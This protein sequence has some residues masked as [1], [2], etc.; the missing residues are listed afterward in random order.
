MTLLPVLAFLNVGAEKEPMRAPEWAIAARLGAC[1]IT[2]SETAAELSDLADR[3]ADAGYTVVTVHPGHLCYDILDYDTPRHW[4]ALKRFVDACHA[5]GMRVVL[6]TMTLWHDKQRSPQ[7]ERYAGWSARHGATTYHLPPR[8]GANAWYSC[9]NHPVI[10]DAHVTKLPAL[11]E[12]TGADGFMTDALIRPD[13]YSCVCEHCRRTFRRDTG[14]EAP[15]SE[16]AD[17]WGRHENPAYRA[18]LLWRYQ[19]VTDFLLEIREALA[20]MERPRALLEY[21]APGIPSMLKSATDHEVLADAGAC[22]IGQEVGVA[23]ASQYNWRF[24][25]AKLNHVQSLCQLRGRVPYAIIHN[26]Y[27]ESCPHLFRSLTWL[28]GLRKWEYPVAYGAVRGVTVSRSALRWDE[29]HEDLLSP[30]RRDADVA[31][32]YSRRSYVLVKATHREGP[33]SKDPLDAEYFGWAEALLE[34]D[35]P[36]HS[37]LD[38]DLT[39]ERLGDY[40]VLILPAIACLSRDSA[41]AIRRFLA[42]GGRLVAVGPTSRYAA[43]GEQLPDFRLA[44]VFG[45]HYRGFSGARATLAPEIGADVPERGFD[46]PIEGFTVTEQAEGSQRA[47]S[48]VTGEDGQPG[49]VTHRYGGGEGIY[50]AFAAGQQT[51]HVVNYL[52]SRGGTWTAPPARELHDVML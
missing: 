33:G 4:P 40:R 42:D 52:G 22:M 28:A 6:K 14:F 51:C 19:S 48:L 17:F 8:P 27:A 37:L 50:V 20:A 5:R 36:Y 10:R 38:G 15:A 12:A 24:I 49:I 41:D 31:I 30:V 9:L 13:M 2:L 39:A 47:A 3:L 21:Y 7:Y 16:E 32:V 1:T 26:T 35:I 43:D 25:L 18:W 34:H 45:V 11:L 44:D 46:V 29:E 23:P